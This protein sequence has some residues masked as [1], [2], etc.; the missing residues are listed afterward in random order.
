MGSL[1][2]HTLLIPTYNRPEMLGPLLA[3]LATANLRIIILDSSNEEAKKAN[4]QIVSKYSTIY[5]QAFPSEIA[6]CEKCLEGL[7]LTKT[8]YVSFLADDDLVF[9][10]GLA[11][12]VKMLHNSPNAIAAQ[13]I[14]LN[15]I[16][17][18][19]FPHHIDL[20]V[21]YACDSIQ[22]GQAGGR[23]FQLLSFYES[24]M[25]AVYRTHVLQEI[26]SQILSLYQK[27][28]LEG[29]FLELFQAVAAVMAGNILR[30]PNIYYARRGGVPSHD[31]HKNCHP[32]F[33][34]GKNPKEFFNAYFLY[35]QA[36]LQ[37]WQERENVLDEDD[38]EKWCD[39]AHWTYLH[40]DVRPELI[41]SCN[42]HMYNEGRNQTTFPIWP[43]GNF[44]R[45]KA[46]NKKTKKIWEKPFWR[47]PV[48]NLAKGVRKLSDL[49]VK[50]WENKE[51]GSQAT[52]PFS[53]N[54]DFS[55]KADQ[56]LGIFSQAPGLLEAIEDIKNLVRLNVQNAN[57]LN[58][59]IGL[60]KV[61]N[62]PN[63]FNQAG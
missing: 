9:P 33:W 12:C 14:Y 41:F 45:K 48:Y 46:E 44:E 49:M 60:E 1:N 61:I 63:Q 62:M 35:R 53:N 5:Y 28:N 24:P 22:A 52:I 42:P 13:G 50:M 37:W 10:D 15:F 4:R 55:I 39:L 27:G 57:I 11:A 58:N 38:K 36:V 40:R 43:L 3:Q 54:E 34:M 56:R 2:K 29:C 6:A 31:I 8:P 25:Y 51:N 18:Q 59:R 17:Q 16:F 26:F 30:I 32:A 7:S 21:E 23:L 20:S 47:H 19:A